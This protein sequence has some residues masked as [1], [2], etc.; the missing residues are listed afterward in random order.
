MNST[1][2]WQTWAALGVV[3]ATALVFAIRSSKKKKSG[4]CGSCGCGH[5]HDKKSATDKAEHHH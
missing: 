2:D 5:S 4:G 3:I 1:I